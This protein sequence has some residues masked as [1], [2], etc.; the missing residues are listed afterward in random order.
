MNRC[1]RAKSSGGINMLMVNDW[2]RSMTCIEMRSDSLRTTGRD[3]D[4]KKERQAKFP[5]D[6]CF[7][8]SLFPSGRNVSDTDVR[9]FLSL[10]SEMLEVIDEI[11]TRSGSTQNDML[12]NVFSSKI[13]HH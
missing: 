9:G 4:W 13:V 8:S 7:I 3:A 2:E 5:A 6:N 12:R 11:T 1:S 10:L